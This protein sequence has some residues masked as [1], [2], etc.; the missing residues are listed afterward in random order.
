MNSFQKCFEERCYLGNINHNPD[1]FHN[2]NN[3]EASVNSSSLLG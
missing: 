2:H 1:D 3:V